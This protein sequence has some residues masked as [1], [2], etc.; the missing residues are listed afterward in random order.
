MAVIVNNPD[1]GHTIESNS[2][3]NT[4]L[5]VVILAIVV[6]AL[7]YYGLP[8]LRSGFQAPQINVPGQIDVNV[9]QPNK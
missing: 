4:L 6:F 8:A 2:G 1:H 9:N 3:L 7:L 5:G